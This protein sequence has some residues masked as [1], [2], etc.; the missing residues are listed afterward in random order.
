MIK[1]L[2]QARVKKIPT[3]RIPAADSGNFTSVR[4]YLKIILLREF[5]VQLMS[6]R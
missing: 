1:D 4:G 3:S 2:R 6:R 5:H